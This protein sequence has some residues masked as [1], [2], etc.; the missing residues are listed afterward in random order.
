[1]EVFDGNSDF[2]FAEMGDRPTTCGVIAKP[3][4]FD[5]H[6]PLYRLLLVS[7][8]RANYRPHRVKIGLILDE[9]AALKRVREVE[10]A[11]GLT[12][13]FGLQLI[14]V[15]QSFRNWL[16]Y[17]APRVGKISWATRAP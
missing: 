9:F 11:Q 1:M 10:Q 15:V 3:D 17:T 5:T 14:I 4:T 8:M 12:A 16:S 13:G 2:D 6:G 7:V